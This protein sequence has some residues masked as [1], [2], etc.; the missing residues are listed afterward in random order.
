MKV[1]SENL[2][3]NTITHLLNTY[4]INLPEGMQNYMNM[5]ADDAKLLWKMKSCY[6]HKRTF[7][8]KEKKVMVQLYKSVVCPHLDYC[9]QAWRPHFQNDSCSGEGATLGNKSHSRAKSSLVSGTLEGHRA[10]NTPNQA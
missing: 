6:S 3:F 4:I 8:F 2:V 5:F 9:I 1:T 10:Y 7:D